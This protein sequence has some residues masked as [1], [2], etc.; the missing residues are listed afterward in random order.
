MR[1]RHS[2]Q[3][4]VHIQRAL[5][6][7]RANGHWCVFCFRGRIHDRSHT[8]K[9]LLESLDRNAPAFTLVVEHQDELTGYALGRQGS[10]ADH[11]GPWVSQDVASARALLDEFLQRSC[12]DTIFVDWM[13]SSSF[14]GPLLR[15]Y[16]FELTRP[17][18]RM[19]RGPNA[20]PRQTE[21]VCAILGPEFG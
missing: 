11:L 5:R 17:L 20:C 13:T 18:T 21:L 10:R 12:R 9:G 8:R 19:Y 2:F 16:G 4:L 7:I 1:G 3:L 15:S 6:R 14:A